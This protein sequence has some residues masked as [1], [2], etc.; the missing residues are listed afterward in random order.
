M[1]R[2]ADSTHTRLS[3]VDL[4]LGLSRKEIVAYSRFKRDDLLS[5]NLFEIRPG[6]FKAKPQLT[7]QTANESPRNHRQAWPFEIDFLPDLFLPRHCTTCSSYVPIRFHITAALH[8]NIF[9]FYNYLLLLLLLLL[10]YN[11]Y[12]NVPIVPSASSFATISDII[13]DGVYILLL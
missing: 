10:I 4:G 6:V 7:A 11:K 9:I 5:S 8:G 1:S 12:I 3:G 2:A 13:Q